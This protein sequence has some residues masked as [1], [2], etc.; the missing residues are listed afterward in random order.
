MFVLFNTFLRY[1]DRCNR[2]DLQPCSVVPK[3]KYV[4]SHYQQ[5]N[6]KNLC[7]LIYSESCNTGEIKVYKGFDLFIQVLRVL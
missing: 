7:K 6:R 3:G 4:N 5:E 2:Y 1:C